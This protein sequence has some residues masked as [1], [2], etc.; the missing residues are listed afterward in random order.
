MTQVFA[1]KGWCPGALRPMESGDGLIVRVRPRCGAITLNDFKGLAD[2]A[3]LFGNGEID[4]TRRANLQLRGLN[5]DGLPSVHQRLDDL[6]LLDET[7]EAEAVRNVVVAPM[8]GL[9]KSWPV[10]GRSVAGQLEDRLRQ[11]ERLW[12]L[13]GKFGFAIDDGSA[14]GLDDYG[15]DIVLK[16]HVEPDRKSG[17]AGDDGAVVWSVIAGGAHVATVS[18]DD[19]V[20]AAVVL[21]TAFAEIAV[22]LGLRRFKNAV[23]NHEIMSAIERK[24]EAS[25]YRDPQAAALAVNA[26]W[27]GRSQT[28]WRDL[29]QWIALP[30]GRINA[31]QVHQL[32][33]GLEA[34]DVSEVRLSPWRALYVPVAG[35]GR[36][37][38]E[39]KA[40]GVDAGLITDP[41]DPLLRVSACTGAPGCPQAFI[42]TRELARRLASAQADHC[43][44]FSI[45]VSGCAKSCASSKSADLSVVGCADGY[46]IGFGLTAADPVG[47]MVETEADVE[48]VLDELA[49]KSELEELRA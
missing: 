24:L 39:I 13:P 48:A 2:I 20:D 11:D 5:E 36:S 4:L 1:V 29:A 9:D 6:R 8:A 27:A 12:C 30:F 21:A 22:P 38:D 37:V 33:A 10:D 16:A 3:S 18:A 40:V 25:S 49:A 47:H 31:Q 15:T 19:V 45:H 34:I 14:V 35:E 7:P 23:G 26:G 46:G 32:C 28:D 43:R 17:A 41:D 44:S 42:K